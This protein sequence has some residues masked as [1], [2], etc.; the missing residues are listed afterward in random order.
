MIFEILRVCPPIE[1]QKQ[2]KKQKQNKRTKYN[3]FVKFLGKWMELEN[4]R[5]R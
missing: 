1:K 4:I 2:T 3:D 5:V